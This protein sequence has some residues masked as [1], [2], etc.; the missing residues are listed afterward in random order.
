[1]SL[2]DALRPGLL[3]PTGHEHPAVGEMGQPA[4]E[5][6][7][8]GVD[9]D[10][11]LRARRRIP[12]GRACVVVRGREAARVVGE[13]FAVRQQRD[14][15]ADDRPVDDRTPLADVV[16]GVGDGDGG[17]PCV[18]RADGARVG[19]ERSLLRGR[20][21]DR[22]LG[23]VAGGSH[24]SVVRSGARRDERGHDDRCDERDALSRQQAPVSS[25]A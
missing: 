13:D 24:D 1:V 14:V 11:G 23:R 12:H 6:V 16:R 8:A 22:I 3:V 5:D 19:V 18:G 20:E 7:E 2:D 25:S 9:G 4:A 21:R 17:C 10:R 15:H